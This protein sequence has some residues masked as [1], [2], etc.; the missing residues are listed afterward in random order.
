MP[1]QEITDDKKLDKRRAKQLRSFYNDRV[2]RC[3]A[4]H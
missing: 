4:T 3:T 1:P 2:D